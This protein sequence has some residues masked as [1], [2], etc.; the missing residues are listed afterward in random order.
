MEHLQ[1]VWL[2]DRGRLLLKKPGP[3]PFVFMLRPFI[4]EHCMS[5]DLLKFEHPSVL[6]FCV[7]WFVYLHANEYNR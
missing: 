7:S 6:L 1:R 2:A 4:P 5:S 3:V